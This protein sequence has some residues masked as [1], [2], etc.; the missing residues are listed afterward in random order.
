MPGFR[1]LLA[2]QEGICR[3][4]MPPYA[5]WRSNR[6]RSASRAGVRG[7]LNRNQHR[8][9]AALYFDDQRGE[10]RAALAQLLQVRHPGLIDGDDDVIAADAGRSG[11]A[12]AVDI[13]HHDAAA[14]GGLHQ[15]GALEG[16]IDFPRRH[17]RCGG[18]F[19][20]LA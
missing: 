11:G 18:R 5:H 15:H 3:V 8:G 13:A 10:P 2:Q 19:R 17:R 14:A 4:S 9:L 12:A 7:S 1:R 6:R 16:R 20:R